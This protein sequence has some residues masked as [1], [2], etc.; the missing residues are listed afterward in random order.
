MRVVL[1]EVDLS[2]LFLRGFFWGPFYRLGVLE[3]VIRCSG[4][5]LGPFYCLGVLELVIW[6]SGFGCVLYTPAI[7]RG[8]FV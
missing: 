6:C 1:V 5:F 2:T 7:L 3:L 4:F 8:V